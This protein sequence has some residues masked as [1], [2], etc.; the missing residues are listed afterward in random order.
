LRVSFIGEGLLRWFEAAG[1]KHLPWQVRPSAYRVWVSEVM[2]QQTRVATVVPYYERFMVQFPD[3]E[4]LASAAIDEV[5]HLWTGLGYYARARN[6]H[7]AAQRVVQDYGGRFPETL[8]AMRSL[9]GVGRSTAAAILALS[10]SRRHAILDGNVKRV[11]TR[12]FGVEGFPGNAAVERHL[13]MLAEACTPSEGVARYTQ[14][15][16]DLGATVCVRRDPSC[17]V[18]PL[19]DLCVAGSEGRQSELPT[20]RPKRHRPRREAYVVILQRGDGAVLLERRPPVG[21]WGGLWT[22]PQ[23]DDRESAEAW[24]TSAAPATPVSASRILPAYAHAFT[25]F[26]LT[27]YPLLVAVRSGGGVADMDRYCWYDPRRPARIGLAKPAVDLIAQA[28][29]FLR[30]APA[31]CGTPVSRKARC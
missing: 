17:P 20:P 23:Y 24:W 19:R 2:L 11:L 6:L 13:W 14:A 29:E 21:L 10:A 28:E 5:L 25:H 1:R 8:E 18:C 7:R 4:S 9:P 16:M 31:R 15:I 26:D 12:Y 3:V 27:L 30:R 22:L